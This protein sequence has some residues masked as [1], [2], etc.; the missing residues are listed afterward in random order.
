MGGW[1]IPETGSE[2]AIQ[3]LEKCSAKRSKAEGENKLAKISDQHIRKL[4]VDERWVIFFDSFPNCIKAEN[5]WSS[6]TGIPILF[7]P[8]AVSKGSEKE[9]KI[10]FLDH[11][12]GKVRLLLQD[13]QIATAGDPITGMKCSMADLKAE[14]RIQTTSKSENLSLIIK[15]PIECQIG[16][17]SP[18]LKAVY[19]QL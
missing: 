2:K 1:S 19:Y 14:G 13:W 10:S 18:S 8:L 5:R 16:Q 17:E 4:P 9:I 15:F 3:V 6:S 7:S 11:L 12:D